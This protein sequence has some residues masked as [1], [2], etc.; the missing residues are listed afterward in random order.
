VTRSDGVY[1][2]EREVFAALGARLRREFPFDLALSALSAAFWTAIGLAVLVD[3]DVGSSMIVIVPCLLRLAWL[4]RVW[5]QRIAQ[6]PGV[7]RQ[8]ALSR[9]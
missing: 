7:A 4:A 5:R 2:L 1:A 3:G 9:A 8:F 6:S